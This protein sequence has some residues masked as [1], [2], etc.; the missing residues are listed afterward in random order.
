L[1]RLAGYD[2][3][4]ASRRGSFGSRRWPCIILTAI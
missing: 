2:R 1:G 4:I 3:S